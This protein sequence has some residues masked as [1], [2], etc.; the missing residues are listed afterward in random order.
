MMTTAIVW[1]RRDLRLADNPALSAALGAHD[2]VLPVYVH[3]PDEEAPWQPGA[4][5]R[6]W[7]HHS[8]AALDADLNRRGA[9]LHL[10]EGNSLDTLRRLAAASGAHAVYWNRLYD[11]ATVARD[12]TVKQALRADGLEARSFKAALLHEPWELVSGSG[13]PYRVF[14]PYWRNA[15]A[16]LE[17]RPPLP[18]PR[19]IA[20]PSFESGLALGRLGLL[21]QI[22]W[23][24]GLAAAWRPGEAAAAQR[25]QKFCTDG[26][27]GYADERDIPSHDGTSRLSP[28]LHFGEISPMQVAWAL[29]DAA[30][31]GASAGGAESCLR[32]LGWR[33]FS[34]YLIH[35]APHSAENDLNPRFETF[36]WAD[37]APAMLARWQHGRTGIPIIDAG[38]RELWTTGW[39]HNRVRMLVAS[40][41][42]KNL[43]FHWLHGARWFWDTLVDADLGNN[44]QGWQWTAGTGVDASPYFRVFNPVV[45]G[46]RFDPDGVYVRR[47]VPELADFPVRAIH[48]PWR[49]PQRSLAC[50][51]PAPMVDLLATRQSALDAYRCLRD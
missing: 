6:W 30:R 4:A 2:A 29:L 25:L 45:Q 33:E 24:V 43:R 28:Y 26:V 7:L 22:A 16:R 8:L 35:H 31:E 51:Y 42:T 13:T 46:E 38:M 34:Q 49:D 11:P 48:A 41:L 44:T 15:R 17:V 37:P 23:D 18:A 21:P 47:W 1:L 5:S 3:A 39:M 9:F 36:E 12:A 14:T 19:R 10:A 27:A 50:G 20:T 40:F 32:E